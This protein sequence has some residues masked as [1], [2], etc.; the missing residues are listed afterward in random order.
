MK[1]TLITFIT[2][3]AL[4]VLAA[5]VAGATV[6][7]DPNEGGILD[8]RD[9]E[10]VSYS[11]DGTWHEWVMDLYLAPT[12]ANFA[13]IYGIAIDNGP[14]GSLISDGILYDPLADG[15]DWLVD[16]HYESTGSLGYVKSDRHEWNEGATNYDTVTFFTL[17]P[18]ATFSRSGD[19]LTWRV[20]DDLFEGGAGLGAFSF[21]G[22]SLD[23]GSETGFYDITA[24]GAN[25]P[26]PAAVWL[27]GS[28]LL[29][30][31]GLRKRLG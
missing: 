17:D 8:G 29:G 12:A 10:S 13:G 22:Y 15:L 14:G 28:G 1:K 4:V 7:A 31:V 27:L 18:D 25:V 24:P 9:I 19:L 20:K 6:V 16:A 2:A 23:G 11:F 5:A 26:V 30:L 3:T 21:Y